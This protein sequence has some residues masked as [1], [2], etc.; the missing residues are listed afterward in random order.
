M[1]DVRQRAA[2][3]GFVLAWFA[4][5]LIVVGVLAFLSSPMKNALAIGTINDALESSGEK[6]RL[7]GPA[8]EWGSA[9]R[10]SLAGTR[11]TLEKGQGGAIVFTLT[12]GGASVNCV[13]LIREDGGVDKILP[14]GP[15]APATLDRLP[16]GLVQSY[17]ARI[18]KSE[19]MARLR[20][21]Q[22]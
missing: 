18:E 1:S 14:L 12:G 22:K 7:S 16:D 21:K 4:V 5:S 13:A 15:G 19:R 11:F 10:A 2:R 17:I 9:G 6:R 20:E 3:Y 8:S